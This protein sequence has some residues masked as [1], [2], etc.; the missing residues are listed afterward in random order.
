M[1]A[2]ILALLFST[3]HFVRTIGT[4]L[5]L[6]YIKKM[7]RLAFHCFHSSG[8][9]LHSNHFSRS[10]HSRVDTS[11][12][13]PTD[14]KP[15]YRRPLLTGGS[16]TESQV[17]QLLINSAINGTRF[18]NDIPL[19]SNFGPS[20][21][22]QAAT[23]SPK[24]PDD[25]FIY[26][27][28]P[29]LCQ[30]GTPWL[31]DSRSTA[32]LFAGDRVPESRIGFLDRLCTQAN[33]I[34]SYEEA[35]EHTKT[36]LWARILLCQ[37]G[38]ALSALHERKHLPL[39]QMGGDNMS[40]TGYRRHKF[41][42]QRVCEGL[43]TVVLGNLDDNQLHLVEGINATDLENLAVF[44][45]PMSVLEVSTN[46]ILKQQGCT[47]F[48]EVLHRFEQAAEQENC[49]V[50]DASSRLSEELEDV[51]NPKLDSDNSSRESGQNAKGSYRAQAVEGNNSSTEQGESSNET[52]GQSS[53]QVHQ[54]YRMHDMDEFSAVSSA[55]VTRGDATDSHLQYVQT[56]KRQSSRECRSLFLKQLGL[57]SVPSDGLQ[58][59]VEIEQPEASRFLWSGVT[60]FEISAHIDNIVSLITGT[61]MHQ[62]VLANHHDSDVE[63]GLNA[64][65]STCSGSTPSRMDLLRESSQYLQRL[66]Y[67]W[68]GTFTPYERRAL[69]FLG[70]VSFTGCVQQG[71]HG[72]SRRFSKPRWGGSG[73]SRSFRSSALLHDASVLLQFGMRAS[74]AGKLRPEYSDWYGYKALLIWECQ[75]FCHRGLDRSDEVPAGGDVAEMDVQDGYYLAALTVLGFP[76]VSAGLSVAA[77]MVKVDVRP[78]G[79]PQNVGVQ[80]EVDVSEARR[81][82][83]EVRFT[84]VMAPEPSV[85]NGVLKVVM[86]SNGRK[87]EGGGVGR[88]GVE[89]MVVLTHDWVQENGQQNSGGRS[90]G[91]DDELQSFDFEAWAA[92]F[93]G[94]MSEIRC[95]SERILRRST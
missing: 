86:R 22:H 40:M 42:I 43:P 92:A 46:A 90:D 20:N 95:R 80:I 12:S 74:V 39:E 30:F 28:I 27:S 33:L 51:E 84:V 83:A 24:C 18:F 71:I 45:Y 15:T 52:G 8:Y 93:D 6:F 75:N 34:A 72:L 77:G 82:H 35:N 16:A 91:A 88:T 81:N 9:Q 89:L 56:R 17:G 68:R 79:G 25:Y 55:T 64:S 78:V 57:N 31:A 87:G 4:L 7:F 37:N 11:G 54:Q 26:W 32:S 36:S 63:A 48:N 53:R 73:H 23:F 5:N 67:E 59:L 44:L 47:G 69:G 85:G 65:M 10:F 62:I 58:A 29:F 13:F 60:A 94:R 1:S 61:H 49:A 41:K 14:P 50:S 76:S 66:T 38:S 19:R 70:G 3:F 21:A 2:G